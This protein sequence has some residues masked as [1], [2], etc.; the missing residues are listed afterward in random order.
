[1]KAFSNLIILCLASSLL[2][3]QYSEKQ[4]RLGSQVLAVM[5][6]TYGIYKD[7]TMQAFV[8]R[9]GHNLEAQ[10][11]DQYKFQYFITDQEELNA[12]ATAGGYV[13]VTRGLL[14]LINTEDELACV[15]GHE[16]THVT[17]NHTTKT[18]R[19][20][21]LPKILELPANIIG[22]LT[23]QELAN[24][25]NFP[26]EASSQLV[27]SSF[28]R[29]QERI[30]DRKGVE[31]AYKA[32]YDPYML[33]H[34]LEK[35]DKFS[36]TIYGYQHHFSLFDDHP[37]TEDRIE[38]IYTHLAKMQVE[39]KEIQSGSEL[40]FQD[41][42]IFGRNPRYGNIANNVFVHGGL[43]AYIK[44]PKSFEVQ[45]TTKS[46]T[47]V[48]PKMNKSIIVSID[49]LSNS[50][51]VTAKAELRIIQGVEIISQ[52]RTRV[53]G[54]EAY[55]AVMEYKPKKQDPLHSEILWIKLPISNTII[56][57]V[58]IRP[59]E[60]PD[61]RLDSCLMSIR[62][63]RAEELEQWVF[64]EFK[65]IEEELPTNAAKDQAAFLNFIRMI[66][67][68]EQNENSTDENS[69]KVM[70]VKTIEEYKYRLR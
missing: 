61:P 60:D 45:G 10:L 12:F 64:Y 42:L 24:I 7:S 13:F 44:F 29:G 5:D 25:I 15:L 51:E 8:E 57:A 63:L 31:L 36:E 59:K 35:M 3:A 33:P 6:E 20:S 34:V 4:K 30:A 53:N 37:M 48:S 67:D 22:L 70:E 28:S 16:I 58:T 47:A 9:V 56:R 43:R 55:K 69:L 50:P 26:I 68:L 2:H 52:D 32:G 66:N 49:S 62:Q 46:V 23:F 39:E 54:L 18:N 11:E 40:A 19:A 17:E 14:G 1:M 65:L 38:L 27:I 41:G 21:I